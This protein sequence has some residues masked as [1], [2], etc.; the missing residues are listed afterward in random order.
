MWEGFMEETGHTRQ[1]VRDLL[2]IAEDMI[3]IPEV[4]EE[5]KKYNNPVLMGGGINECL[6]EVELALMALNKPYK[7][8][9]KF[10]Y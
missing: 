8:Y 3:W 1:E 6:R 9:K 5:L 2:E 4:M 10:T 7:I